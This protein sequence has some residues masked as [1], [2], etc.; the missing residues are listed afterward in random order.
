MQIANTDIGSVITQFVLLS[1]VL[2]GI[3]GMIIKG[4]GITSITLGQMFPY[5]LAITGALVG[6]LNTIDLVKQRLQEKTELKTFDGVNE[7][8]SITIANV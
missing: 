5:I 2:T 7:N 3:T 8:S 4:F 1:G 6:V